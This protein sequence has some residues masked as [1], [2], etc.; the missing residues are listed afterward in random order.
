MRIALTERFQADVAERNEAER[1]AVVTAVV[2]LP[3]AL[4]RPHDHAG[5][6]LRKLHSSGIWEAR[7]GL[8]LR[9]VFTLADNTLTLVR[10]GTHDDVRRFLRTL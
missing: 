9:M 2:A 3:K 7:V 6:G 1:T 10:L 5:L 4:G 8:G